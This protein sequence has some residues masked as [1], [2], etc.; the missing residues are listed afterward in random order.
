LEG[1]FFIFLFLFNES[2]YLIN[3]YFLKFS[4]ENNVFETT[5]ELVSHMASVSCVSVNKAQTRVQLINL[6]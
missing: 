6:I 4:P 1:F 5:H 2:P 3:I